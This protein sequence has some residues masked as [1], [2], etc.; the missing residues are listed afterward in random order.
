MIIRLQY[1]VNCPSDRP[2]V[3]QF[4]N[5]QGRRQ[6]WVRKTNLT[7]HSRNGKSRLGLAPALCIASQYTAK[8]GQAPAY[9]CRLML[10]DYQR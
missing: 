3:R 8:L 9:I 6:P 5:I 4:A 1:Q 10:V 2:L 7:R